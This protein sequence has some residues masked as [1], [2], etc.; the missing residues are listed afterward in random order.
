MSV[1]ITQNLWGREEL[2]RFLITTNIMLFVTAL[3]LS[4][5]TVNTSLNPMVFL[6]PGTDVLYKLGAS[7]TLPVLSEDRWWTLITANYLHGSLLHLA[8]NMSALNSVGKINMEIYAPSR[9]FL[10]YCLG[11]IISM[12][13]SSLAGIHLTLGASGA[14][15]ALIGSM[16][17][18][19]WRSHKGNLKMR[20]ASIGVWVFLIALIGL[21]LPAVN[22]WAHAAGY[23]SGFFLGFC[24][25]PRVTQNEKTL[26]R[27]A[28]TTAMLITI[29]TLIYGLLFS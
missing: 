6:S 27:V 11:G 15:C 17:Y 24:F 3:M 1:F 25:W 26:L 13:V 5:Q 9:F 8:F 29:A 28:A 7:G 22:N 10:I 18:D 16:S 21:I 19:D 14:V 2:I 12:A 4:P 23:F 20:I